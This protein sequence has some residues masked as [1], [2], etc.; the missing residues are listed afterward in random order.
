MHNYQLFN[1]DIDKKYI[2]I[3]LQKDK[4]IFFGNENTVQQY[5]LIDH[6]IC[7]VLPYLSY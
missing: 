6:A 2:D 3:I 7:V 1:L 5:K 4:Y